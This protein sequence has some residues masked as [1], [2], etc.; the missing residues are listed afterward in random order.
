MPTLLQINVSSNYGS[1]GKIA[2]QIGI[3][4]QKNGWTCY[5]A[6]GARYKNPS[7]LKTIEIGSKREE[8]L[9][10]I[11]SLLQDKHG[12]GSENATQILVNQIKKEI[13]PDL[14]HLHNIH[15]YYI[16]YQILFK[17]LAEANIPVIWTLHDCWTY[18][19]HCAHY[20][21]ANCYKW[22]NKC[23]ECPCIS[24]YPKSLFID[25]STSNFLNKKEAFT[26][27][28]NLTIVTVSKWLANDV[29][30]SF[31]KKFPIKVIYNGVDTKLFKPMSVSKTELNLENKFIILGVANVWSTG[32]GLE[33]F[34]ELRQL[35]SDDYSI[36]L[37]G[38]N[39]AQIKALPKGIIGISR[40]RNVQELI[41]YY[42]V[43]DVY[44]NSSKGETFGMTT[45]EAMACGTPSIV[46]NVT[47]CPELIS[48]DT[49]FVVEPKDFNSLLNIFRKL[50]ENGVKQY[51]N[52]CRK[53]VIELFYNEDR[54]KEYVKLYNEILTTH[55]YE[56]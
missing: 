16:N 25:N 23:Y 45:V 4:A 52:P 17:Y 9:H 40:T 10:G 39:K 50:K 44:F 3:L 42:S 43:A 33:D 48:E 7:Q 26:S 27:I 55:K 18:T 20:V 30:K 32:K 36:I 28:K 5:L 41:K 38:L 11:L 24:N 51:S 47:A 8:V 21:F 12:L 15:G 6:H 49:G 19:G 37:I 54:Y 31:F 14:I 56:A 34:I 35:L 53:R 2:E 1:T 22:E 46:Y 13:N 29:K